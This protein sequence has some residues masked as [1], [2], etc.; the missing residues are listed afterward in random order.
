MEK[1]ASNTLEGVVT[2]IC[3]VAQTSTLFRLERL[4]RLQILKL[5]LNTRASSILKKFLTTFNAQ[6]NSGYIRVNTYKRYS[7]HNVDSSYYTL[8]CRLD[9]VIRQILPIN[10]SSDLFRMLL[11]VISLVLSFKYEYWGDRESWMVIFY[12]QGWMD[13]GTTSN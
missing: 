13:E 2:V 11:V 9:L 8:R 5:E 4:S 10:T 7:I 1:P 3:K 12:Y 6:P